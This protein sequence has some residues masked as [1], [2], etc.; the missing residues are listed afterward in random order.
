M[1]ETL[2]PIP[3]RLD[4]YAKHKSKYNRMQMVKGDQRGNLLIITLKDSDNGTTFKPVSLTD[5]IVRV[6]FLKEDGQVVDGQAIIADALNG[7]ITYLIQGNEIAY[8]GEVLAEVQVF[9]VDSR[10]TTSQFSFQVLDSIDDGSAIESTTEYNLITSLIGDVQ[11]IQASENLIAIAEQQRVDSE[12]AR[13][14]AAIDMENAENAREDSFITALN[15]V[16]AAKTNAEN[17]ILDANNAITLANEQIDLVQS[18]VDDSNIATGLANQAT[19]NANQATTLA[20]NAASLADTARAGI[21]GQYNAVANDLSQHKT[22]YATL[23]GVVQQL[24]D[25]LYDLA[26]KT[27]PIVEWQNG[28]INTLGTIS[29]ETSSNFKHTPMYDVIIG[30]TYKARLYGQSNATYDIAIFNSSKALISDLSKLSNGTTTN[31]EFTIT[32]TRAKYIQFCE[33]GAYVTETSGHYA[34]IVVKTSKIDTLDEKIYALEAETKETADAIA[35]I[36]IANGFYMVRED[37]TIGLNEGLTWALYIPDIK[38]NRIVTFEIDITTFGELK[39]GT[40]FP[41]YGSSYLDI[42]A[43]SIKLYQVFPSV[44]LIATYEHGLTIS[45]YLKVVVMVKYNDVADI[46]ITTSTGSYT[47]T[48]CLFSGVSGNMNI[49]NVSGVYTTL[50]MSFASNELKKRTWVFGDSYLDYWGKYIISM[51]V[52]NWLSDGYPG[53]NSTIALTSLKSNLIF[54]KPTTIIWALGMND[55]D[56]DITINAAWKSA[57]D[58]VISICDEKGIELV[59]V[60]IPNTPNKNNSFKNTYI[61]NSG[62]KY[63]D[64]AKIVGADEDGQW[65]DGLMADDNTHPTELGSKIIGNEFI[66]CYPNIFDADFNKI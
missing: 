23:G 52:K 36:N 16:A 11:T 2:Q 26:S 19:T 39:I 63:V 62:K 40:S 37:R 56:S 17:A 14:L 5:A 45:E 27:I 10:Y 57:T 4:L 6:V 58:E 32:D 21:Q 25:T 1:P 47:I 43:T 31:Y 66:C 34:Q 28:Y 8:V 24:E 12:N 51:G 20:T 7:I 38:N 33:R 41:N 60:T 29:D 18:A 48:N 53:R 65:Y 3:Y 44:N 9:G 46:I 64:I 50:K 15:E 35:D 30:E 49:Q 55:V 13:K 54:N 59:L 61:K 22:D 42:D